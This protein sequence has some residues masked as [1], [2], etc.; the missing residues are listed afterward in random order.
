M[1]DKTNKLM[2]LFMPTKEIFGKQSLRVK[3][4]IPFIITVNMLLILA[5]TLLIF[6]EIFKK[7]FATL[8]LVL[9]MLGL[10]IT[11]SLLFKYKSPLAGA[12]LDTAGFIIVCSGLAFFVGDLSNP[13]H[14]YQGAFWIA[15]MS[16]ANQS[17]A[18]SRR[19]LVFFFIASML[20]FG[21]SCLI[22]V[23]DYLLINRV[24]TITAVASGFLVL[25]I[26][27]V[28]ILS[29]NKMDHTLI[30]TSEAAAKKSEETLLILSGILDHAK[31]GF[32]IG[33]NLENHTGKARSDVSK[34]GEL[35]MYLTTESANLTAE[36]DTI[37]DSSTQVLNQVNNMKNSVQSQNAAITQTS[38]AIT[39][40]SANLTNISEIAQRRKDSMNA[41]VETL[42]AQTN[43]IKKLVDEMS[44]V[45]KYSDGI[46]GFVTTVDNIAS[47][48]S[49]LAMNASIEAAHAGSFGKGFG[50]IAQEIRKLSEETA[51]NAG[52]I[53]EVLKNNSQIVSSA[54]SSASEFKTYVERST[55]ELKSTILAI[56]EILSGVTEM[57]LGTREVMKAIQDIVDESRT[58]GDLVEDTV[59]E[60]TEQSNAIKHVSE[61][62]ATLETRV[63]SLDELL[64]NIK[65]ALTNVQQ[66]AKKSAEVTKII[67]SSLNSSNQHNTAET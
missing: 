30:K 12:I 2:S 35:Y 4:Q 66:E 58:T 32:D 38:A 22:F 36:T 51:K 65:T 67:S 19:Q 62:A 49:L 60:I 27:N 41:I 29:L 46:N 56:E 52:Q 11:A 3:T 13:L 28:T 44:N 42:N 53:S 25:V 18:L 1:T 40:I 21:V 9:F 63:Q 37:K 7:D 24:D 54:S 6:V 10:Y 50:V 61:F 14:L 48:T 17:V 59:S 20:I 31:K 39:E 47:Q 23:P 34:I 8:M 64:T 16:T 57:D 26:V 5:T 33:N 55:E 43:L 45:Q 15:G